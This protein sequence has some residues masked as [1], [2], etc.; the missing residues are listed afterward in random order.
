MGDAEIYGRQESDVPH[1]GRLVGGDASPW[2]ELEWLPC[3]DG[4]ARPTQPGLF[5]LAHG[6][7]ARMGRLRAYGNAIVPQVVAAFIAAYGHA[8]AEA[9]LL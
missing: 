9:G 2:S 5:P 8:R 6:I 7:P 3:A 1:Q 4:K